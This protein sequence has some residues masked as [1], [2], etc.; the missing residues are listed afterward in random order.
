MLMISRRRSAVICVLALLNAASLGCDRE[1]TAPP[2]AVVTHVATNS[3][4]AEQ[5]P[6][7]VT[8]PQVKKLANVPEW[9]VDAV[10]YQIFPERFRNGDPKNDPT[11]ESLE[12]PETIP[13]SWR[14]SPR[15]GDWYARADWEKQ[16]GPSF[17][18]NGVFNRRYGG[19]LQGVLDKLDYLADLGINAIYF[20]PV[21]YARSLHKY[22]GASMHHVDPYFGPDPKGDLAL[23]AAESSDPRSWQWTAADKLFL[24][25]IA[26]AHARGIRIIIDGVFNHTGRD[27]FAFA[28][29]R[30]NQSKSPFQDWYI[31]AHFDNPNTPQKEFQYKGWWGNDTLPE[32]ANNTAG[33]DLYAGPKSYVMDVTRRWMDPDGDGNPRDG[34]DGWRLDVAEEV[35]LGFW[36]DWNAHVRK[37]NPQAYTVAEVWNDA[38]EFLVGGGFSATMNYHAF[39]FPMKGYLVDGRLS[40]HD[41]GREL[42][43][44]RE[45]YP[46]A[47]QFALQ[48]LVDSHD[49]DRLASMIV[50]RPVDK[51]YLQ[52][53]RFDYDTDGRVSPRRDPSYSVRKPNDQERRLQRMVVLLQMTSLGAPMVYYGDEAGMWGGDDPCDRWPMFWDDLTYEP[54]THDPLGRPREPDAVSADRELIQFYKDAIAL[55]KQYDALRRGSWSVV[56]TNDDAKFFAFQRELEG[57]RLVVAFNRGEEPFQWT[58]PASKA[59]P[60][61]VFATDK[62]AAL[63]AKTG[64]SSALTLPPL[65]AAVVSQ[66]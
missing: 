48:N 30:K 51:P 66:E 9:A 24:K 13:S 7:A 36:K 19:D 57:V 6:P 49:T 18:E 42:A 46:P 40:P 41:F 43:L 34:I 58:L 10:F 29:L 47:M 35:P 53:D 25:L 26:E 27:F 63:D 39:A 54:Q 17:Y 4:P 20:N 12:F 2:E 31:V 59:N 32:F 5:H 33:D 14:I 15:T 64:H 62:A 8:W 55:R 52:P 21:F 65:S 61:L 44:R 23:I 11:R 3:P 60:S 1:S 38:R 37:L 22:D 56:E 50:N 28:D 16:A 45:K